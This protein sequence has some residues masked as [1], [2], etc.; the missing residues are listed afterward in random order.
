ML[1]IIG[2]YGFAIVPIGIVRKYNNFSGWK[3]DT[4]KG[5]QFWIRGRYDPKQNLIKFVSP[6]HK[7]EDV[8]LTPYFIKQIFEE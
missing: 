2:N 7:G 6:N 4:K 1:F 5:R 8:D 3:L